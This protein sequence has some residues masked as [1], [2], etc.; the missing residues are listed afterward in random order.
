[1]KRFLLASV[2]LA[3]CTTANEE[4]EDIK[5]KGICYLYAYERCFARHDCLD[6]TWTVHPF[7][8]IDA[9]VEEYCLEP[10]HTLEEFHNCSSWFDIA[11][12]DDVENQLSACYF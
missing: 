5:N 8:C 12:C 7:E 3:S 2:L 1:M 6:P 4:T 10:R 9:L 11:S